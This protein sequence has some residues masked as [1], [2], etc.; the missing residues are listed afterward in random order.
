METMNITGGLSLGTLIGDDDDSGHGHGSH[1]M[2]ELMDGG[3]RSKRSRGG[4]S[5]MSGMPSSLYDDCDGSGH[6]MHN[7]DSN[8]TQSSSDSSGVSGS[9]STTKPKSRSGISSNHGGHHNHHNSDLSEKERKEARALERAQ[10][11]EL[12][13]RR[14]ENARLSAL[15]LNENARIKLRARGLDEDTGSDVHHMRQPSSG[16]SSHGGHAPVPFGSPPSVAM[17]KSSARGGDNKMVDSIS[18]HAATK[19]AADEEVRC[20][21]RRSRCLKLYCD[22]F[23]KQHFCTGDCRCSDCENNLQYEDSRTKAIRQILEGRPD[24]FKPRVDASSENGKGGAAHLNGCH[25]KKSACLKKYCECFGA[26]VFCGSKC[27]CSNCKNLSP[28]GDKRGGDNRDNAAEMKTKKQ[29][30]VS[31]SSYVSSSSAKLSAHQ[32]LPAFKEMDLDLTSSDDSNLTGP[33]SERGGSTTPTTSS[34][35]S[36]KTAAAAAA[37]VAAAAAALA[38]GAGGEGASVGAGLAAAVGANLR[39]GA[40]TLRTRRT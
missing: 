17:T 35:L 22:C 5:K 16:M 27:R 8:M 10:Q 23:R 18:P 20:N 30:V 3:G 32:A 33:L 15:Q 25:C 11:K 13:A 12:K 36:N 21:C 24:A 38:L 34:R 39:A 28:D 19:P 2:I 9:G 4:R 6:V 1:S 29:K 26:K 7:D 37:A 40:R 14:A 31:S